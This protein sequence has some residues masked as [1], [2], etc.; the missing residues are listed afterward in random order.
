MAFFP[1]IFYLVE[2]LREKWNTMF[3]LLMVIALHFMFVP[4]HIQMIFYAFLALGIY[5]LFLALR[6]LRNKESWSG[7]ARAAAVV[8]VASGIAFLMDADK[9]L[10]VLEYNPYSIRGMAPIMQSSEGMTKEGGLDYEYATNWSFAP[11]EM[12]TFIIPSWYGFGVHPYQG[13]LSNNQVIKVNT[14]FGPQPFTHAP[15]YMGVVVLVLAVI[16]FVRNRKEPFV[17]YMGIVIVFSMLV[18]FGKEFPL[19]YDPMFKYFPMFNKFRVP[20]MILVLVQIFVPILAAYGLA[21]FIGGRD[22]SMPPAAVKRWK[23]TLGGL[24]GIFGVAL[25]LPSIIR[26]VYGAFFSQEVIGR[27]FTNL[28]AP[29]V[30]ELYNFVVNAVVTD[31]IIG[32]LLLLVAFGALFLYLRRS[33]SLTTLSAVIVLAVVADL[34]RVAYKPMETSDAREFQQYFTMPEYVRFLQQDTTQYRVLEFINGQPPYNNTLAYWRIENAFGY[35]GAKMRWYQDVVDVA[36]LRNPLVWQLMNVRYIITNQPDT[37]EYLSL[38]YNGPDRKVYHNTSALPRA[39]FVNRYEVASGLDILEKIRARAFDPRE[40]AYFVDDPKAS[41]DPPHPAANAVITHYGIQDLQL[42]VTASGN[43]LLFL[44]EAYYP[45][46]WNAYLNG[47]PIPI[48]RVNYMFRGVIVPEGVHTLEMRF[49]PRGFYL[50]KNLSLAAN[51]LVLGA[52][53]FFTVRH[54]RKR[55][56]SG[57]PSS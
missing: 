19:V 38:V 46:G 55:P 36:G 27:K 47:S 2:R 37:A 28:P 48:H 26:G 32:A 57:Q 45:V 35:Q 30:A 13:P 29:Y 43:N 5:G 42:R 12:M 23:Y 4:A 54:F 52:M 17:L 10:S 25:M 34:W 40:V 39:F 31:V 53:G 18:A 1:F 20:S 22:S 15:Q 8:I 44:S 9:Y 49:E 11:G 56:D 6:A 7:I 50:G 33:I 21:S 14:Y 51:I 16:G 24:A 3:A 41:I